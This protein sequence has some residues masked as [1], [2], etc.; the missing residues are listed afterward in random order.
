MKNQ[1]ALLL[2]LSLVCPAA[3]ADWTYLGPLPARGDVF[4]DLA[5]RVKDQKQ[6]SLRLLA[7]YA[8]PHAEPNGTRILS[9]VSVQGFECGPGTTRL[10][11]R[12]TYEGRFAQGK[13]QVAHVP[14]G[15][16]Q[17]VPPASRGMEMMVVACLPVPLLDQPTKDWASEPVVAGDMPLRYDRDHTRREG[18]RLTLRWLMEQPPAGLQPP[19]G[20]VAA[21][22]EVETFIDCGKPGAVMSVGLGRSKPQ[23]QGAAVAI[24]VNSKAA[25][26]DDA[27]PPPLAT[28][29]R[30]LC[31]AP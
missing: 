23:G 22:T 31:A 28:L 21:S 15:P 27:M 8:A 20:Y 7:N 12:R 17:E 2:A 11:D 24:S 5:S 14:D 1:A 30:Q 29:A 9:A 13:A 26:L 10:Q 6:A 16:W 4:V 25:S 19:P 3:F 18:R